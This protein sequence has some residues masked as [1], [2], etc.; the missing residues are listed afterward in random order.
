MKNK[1]IFIFICVLYFSPILAENL[2]IQSL[3]MSLDKKNQITI[4]QNQV[5]AKDE[6]N[7]QLQTEFA[8][9]NKNLQIFKSIGETTLLT[10]NG[11]IVKG[12]DIIMDNVDHALYIKEIMK[13]PEKLKELLEADKA[14]S[15][16]IYDMIKKL[17]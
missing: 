2:N 11:Y 10:S 14:L 3:N 16:M 6:K 15:N 4:F 12:K 17:P 7:N 5:T 8:E 9:Y 1:I 13:N